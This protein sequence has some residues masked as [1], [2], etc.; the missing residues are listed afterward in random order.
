MAV[1]LA[2]EPPTLDPAL[3]YSADG[4][5]IVHAIYD[6]P[7]QIG[8]GGGIE[9]VAAESM[10]Q[11]DPLTWEVRL[12][13]G[14]TFHNGEPLESS[15]IAF[16]I[17]HLL[18]PATASQVAG[19]FAVIEEVEEVDALTARLHLSAPAPWLPS[20]VA[21]WLALLPP[22]YAGDPANDFAA[23]PV[24][25]G[26]YRFVRWD[27]GSQVSLEINEDYL[28]GTAKGRPIAR[29]VNYRFVL[30]G[31]T[32]VTDI[33]SGTS[34]LVA[35][36]PF[37]QLETVAAA[38]AVIDTPIVGTSFVRVPT[39]MPPFDNVQVR[40]AMNHAV[41]VEAVIA[42]LLG[43]HGERLATLFPPGGMGYDPELA[44]H[45]YEPELARQLL[46]EAGYPDGF[47]TRLAYSTSDRSDLATA[48]AGQL[49]TVGISVE[50]EQVEIAT[51]N[52]S[53][54]DPEAAPLRLVTWRPLFDPY[55]LL[56][57]V[58]SSEGFLSRYDDPDAQALIDAAAVEADPAARE[59]I[60]KDLGR[61]LHDSP[62]GIYLWSLTSFYGLA[63]EVPAWTPRPD[64]WVLP[65][66]AGDA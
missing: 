59:E 26:P 31:T 39:D 10:F 56:G 28:T 43:G 30:D 49:A 4:W 3:V 42:S 24:G 62:A 33:V 13:P 8:P 36:V 20:Q 5:S 1:D 51:F 63:R 52:A 35:G 12:R 54:T 15:S 58:I 9:M 47:Q 55:T 23:N 40:L 14:I 45:A 27:R 66:F 21:P 64:D 11:V 65:L 18:D 60:Y 32:R 19:N 53:W 17:A 22:G 7:V 46:A 38:A 2:V 61:V 50:L 34:Q 6:A 16:S 37:D 44:P 57:L 29:R 25:T 41:D 48:I